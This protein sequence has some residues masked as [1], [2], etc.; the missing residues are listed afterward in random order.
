MFPARCVLGTRN[1]PERTCFEVVFDPSDIRGTQDV[2]GAMLLI[3]YAVS[4][5]GAHASG[6]SLF[7][8][9]GW[10]GGGFSADGRPPVPPLR[11]P[12]QLSSPNHPHL[13]VPITPEWMETM[14]NRGGGNMVFGNLW[15]AGTARLPDLQVQTSAPTQH[16]NSQADD[17]SLPRQEV[18]KVRQCY[19]WQLIGI[20]Q[21]RWLMILEGFRADNRRLVEYPVTPLLGP[22]ARWAECL[23]ELESATFHYRRGENE[24]ALQHERKV[25]DD[26]ATVVGGIWHVPRHADQNFEDWS[27]ELGNRLVKAWPNDRAAVNVLSVLLAA[28]WT[29]YFSSSHDGVAI[30]GRYESNS[31][32][33]VAIDLLMFASQLVVAHSPDAPSSSASLAN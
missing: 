21:E 32:P 18:H 17:A 31:G 15:L 27:Q 25:V 28:A 12:T 6:A 22:G 20:E 23:R 14:V 10:L 16:V 2:I 13:L 8:I 26:I 1:T 29:R 7:T 11:I 5:S 33:S 24:Q 4:V 19:G 3:N 9:E 30:S